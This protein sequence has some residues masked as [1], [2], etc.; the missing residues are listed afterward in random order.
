ME[1]VT[2]MFK[3]LGKDD[4]EAKIFADTVFRVEKDIAEVTSIVGV[5]IIVVLCLH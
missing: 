4:D 1:H 3:L 5:V 2:A